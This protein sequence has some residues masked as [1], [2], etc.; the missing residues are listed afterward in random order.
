M[1]IVTVL[2][3]LSSLHACLKVGPTLPYPTTVNWVCC[4]LSF[5]LLQSLPEL[6]IYKSISCL[7]GKNKQTNRSGL[8]ENIMHLKNLIT[9]FQ[10]LLKC[11]FNN[12]YYL[13]YT[14]YY[15]M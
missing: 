14:T 8:N 15:Y 2:K 5:A 7:M 12:N 10:L 6:A 3:R 4:C 11:H 1:C 9:D 13:T